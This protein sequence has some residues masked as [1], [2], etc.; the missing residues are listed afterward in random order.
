MERDLSNFAKYREDHNFIPLKNILTTVY[1]VLKSCIEFCVKDRQTDGP[2]EK[3]V[4]GCD[5]E[6]TLKNMLWADICCFLEKKV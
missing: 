1:C 3:V 6:I 5:L 2:R 4:P